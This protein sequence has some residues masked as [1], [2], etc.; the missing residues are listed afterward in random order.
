[1]VSYSP[2]EFVKAFASQFPK[3]FMQNWRGEDSKVDDK[4]TNSGI[5]NSKILPPEGLPLKIKYRIS[6]SKEIKTLWNLKLTMAEC[7]KGK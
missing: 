5:K 1:M 2:T 3:V 4:W 6:D 7:E